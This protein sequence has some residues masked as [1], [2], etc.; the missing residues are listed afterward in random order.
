LRQ[1]AFVA[2]RSVCALRLLS[3]DA[4]AHWK[5]L[6]KMELVISTGRALH[7]PS[8]LGRTFTL[9]NFWTAIVCV[10]NGG[11]LLLIPAFVEN[12]SVSMAMNLCGGFE[13]KPVVVAHRRRYYRR[14]IVDECGVRTRAVL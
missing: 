6:G 11:R 14:N 2:V 4:A 1:S 10:G 9:R 8:L 13:G 5:S 3:R 7:D 12:P